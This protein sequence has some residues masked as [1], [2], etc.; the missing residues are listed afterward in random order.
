M[1]KNLFPNN[2]FKKRFLNDFA[3]I[4]S[5]QQEKCFIKKFTSL[6]RKVCDVGCSTGEFLKSLEWQGARYGMEINQKAIIEAKKNR[7]NFD[8]NILNTHNFFDIIIFRGTIQH[9][10]NPF[11][12]IRHTNFALK[13]GGLVFFL[14]T[15]NI[16]SIHYKLFN[17][18]P[19]LDEKRNFYLPSI[20]SLTNLMKIYNFKLINFE[21]PYFDTGY[22]RPIVDF[23]FFFL[24]I[25]GFYKKNIPFPGNMMNVV[26]KKK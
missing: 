19:A 6:D 22:D 8:K 10:Q 13:K 11:D 12:Y 16:N 4:K 21:Y 18:L 3:R 17:N 14:A 7:I 9:L 20:S 5:F 1:T 26:F 24:K 25:F 2:Y 15:P 23:F